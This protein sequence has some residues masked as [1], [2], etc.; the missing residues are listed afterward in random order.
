MSG[1]SVVNAAAIDGELRRTNT[2]ELTIFA[3][4]LHFLTKSI[5]TPPAKHKGL[6]DPELRQRRRYLD[7]IHTDGALDRALKRAK[8][9]QSVRNT[10]AGVS[11][12]AAVI[13]SGNI[14]GSRSA[15]SSTAL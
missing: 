12:P 15:A 14:F 7:L 5:E 9:V 3:E 6:Q 11:V 10:L 13:I 2:G 8:I 4:Q 1:C